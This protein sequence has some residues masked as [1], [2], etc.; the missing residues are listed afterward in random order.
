MANSMASKNKLCSPHVWLATWYSQRW[1]GCL[2]FEAPRGKSCAGCS[3][4]HPPS[5]FDGHSKG[6]WQVKWGNGD[7][8]MNTMNERCLSATAERPPHPH[9][10]MPAPHVTENRDCV[11]SWLATVWAIAPRVG[12][13]TWRFCLCTSPKRMI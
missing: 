1:M 6:T 2:H 8:G 12:K 10:A 4:Y 7:R 13:I 5:L 9:K 11:Q 3:S